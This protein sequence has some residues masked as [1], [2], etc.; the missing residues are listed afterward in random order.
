MSVTTQNQSDPQSVELRQAFEWTCPECG[1]DNFARAM[2]VEDPE[3]IEAFAGEAM[4][5]L[6]M[7]PAQVGCVG[8][9][10]LFHTGEDT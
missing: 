10:Q 9:S 4:G 7:A 6:V 5:D 3:I 1:I 8:C 2:T